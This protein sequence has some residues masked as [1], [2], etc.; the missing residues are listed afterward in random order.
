[1]APSSR[2]PRA[3]KREADYSNI[4]VAGRKTGITLKDTGIRDEHGLEPIDGIFSSPE[5]SPVKHNG[6]G[7]ESTIVEEE[8]MDI[9]ESTVP[10]PT[11]VLI[12]RK[13]NGK[14]LLPPPHARSPMKTSLGSSPRRS[15]GPLS[16]PLRNGET[17]SRA[18]S[19]P[20]VN[21]KLDFPTEEPR[22]SI[23][24]SPQRARSVLLSSKLEVKKGKLRSSGRN[25]KR[26]FDLSLTDEDEPDE[27]D[28]TN[29]DESGIGNSVPMHGE[30]GY[31]E[32]DTEVL[33]NDEGPSQINGNDNLEAL[34]N[35]E[36]D[37]SNVVEE[38]EAPL[39]PKRG[40][41]G[42][43]KKVAQ[44]NLASSTVEILEVRV[45]E[46]TAPIKKRKGRPSKKEVVDTEVSQISQLEVDAVKPANPRGRPKAKPVV[47]QDEEQEAE[48]EAE[49]GPEK[50]SKRARH[51]AA[52]TT[53]TKAGRKSKKPAPS[54]RDPN[55]P[56][57]TAQIKAKAP[58]VEPVSSSA[59]FGKPKT[60]SL[61]VLRH[62]TPAEDDGSRLL[63]SGRTSVK[64]IAHWRGERIV[65]G[66]PHLDGKNIV[67]PAIKEVIRT[68]EVITQRPKRNYRRRNLAMRPRPMNA[69]EEEDEDEE[70]WEQEPGILRAEVMQW[71][72]LTQRGVEDFIEDVGQYFPLWI[73]LR[74]SDFPTTDLALAPVAL[75]A[76]T[77]EVK[78]AEFTYAKTL[79]LPFFHSGM[80][81]LPPGGVKRMKN[82]RKNHMVF[83][84]FHGR[85][86]VE[87]AGTVF[88]IGRGGMW[89]VPRGNFYS[90]ANQYQKPARVF[91]AQGCYMEAEPTES[92]EEAGGS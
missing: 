28:T 34:E 18:M 72:P 70:P 31:M 33:L 77:R 85:V 26:P 29:I 92:G 23:E 47:F 81:D 91:F 83:W 9:G 46:D 57:A 1:M 88:S 78:G 86:R 69:V 39:K 52:E 20:P 13:H 89:Q 10:E 30:T 75:E 48:A 41:P 49:A 3:N 51:D 21:R 90:I 50:P 35:T 6:P 24:R 25:R 22:Q 11:E 12:N 17:P 53:P 44:E 65:Y 59:P 45:Y 54:E 55:L 82:S 71:D 38:V 76:L 7:H 62:E 5:K 4:G 15:M 8:D 61:Y 80:V 74:W 58:S 43:P 67:P 32:V 87:V 16:S 27:T 73:Y 84:V 68:E 79:T 2:T 64:P 60:R 19:H 40:R 56:V 66:E 37:A 42:R 63:R 14:P 36:Q